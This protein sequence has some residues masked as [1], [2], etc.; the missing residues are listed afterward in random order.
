M[1]V[2]PAFLLSLP[3]SGSTLLQRLLG[4]HSQIATAPEPWL[5]LPLLY[6][7]RT[8]GVYAEY[9]HRTAATAI[10]E[11]AQRLPNGHQDY[12]AHVAQLASA[13]YDDAS[14]AGTRYFLDKTP[15]YN[16]VAA[17]V[18][19]LFPDAPL[20]VLWRNPLAVV[21]SIMDTWVG[22]RWMPYLHKQDLFTGLERLIAAC[23]RDPQRFVRL[24]YEDLVSD[25]ERELG[26]VL[27][28][29]DL[30]YE[31]GLLSSFTALD[32][33]ASVGD[34][35]GVTRYRAVSSASLERWRLSLGSTVRKHWCLRWLRWIGPERLAFMGYD[36]DELSESLAGAPS[37]ARR[38]A[39]DVAWTA[40][41][42]LWSLAEPDIMKRK[43]AE[44]PA[45]RRVGSHT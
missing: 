39:A 8:D 42:V 20:I 15:R 1:T 33:T 31:E 30:P 5:L 18:A 4:S 7:T 22:G 34:S 29:M 45:W 40:K 2:T 6:A 43:L 9:G 16:L 21:A 37:D 36:L 38:A 10:N 14:P 32:L 28:H 12:S 44:L 27:A 13:L 23:Q 35:A 11:F 41:G 17:D 26:R 24:R 3:R 19:A 25:P